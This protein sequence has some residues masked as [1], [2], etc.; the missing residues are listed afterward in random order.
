VNKPAGDDPG[1]DSLQGPAVTS[2]HPLLDCQHLHGADTQAEAVL[3]HDL[4]L[5]QADAVDDEQVHS[6][7]FQ[8][9]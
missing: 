5:V 4:D 1:Q 9:V 2:G 3:E 7:A 8:T 6:P